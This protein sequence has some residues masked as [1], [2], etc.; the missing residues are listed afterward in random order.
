MRERGV[1]GDVRI[2]PKQHQR[3]WGEAWREPTQQWINLSVRSYFG[4][5]TTVRE[6]PTVTLA[7]TPHHLASPC[8]APFRLFGGATSRSSEE[9]AGQHP[10]IWTMKKPTTKWSRGKSIR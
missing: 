8:V 6:A 7:G 1:Q 3:A 4:F 10:R 5:R 2:A 9:P